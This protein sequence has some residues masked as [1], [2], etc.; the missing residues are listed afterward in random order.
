MVNKQIFQL[1]IALCFLIP[2]CGDGGQPGNTYSVQGRYVGNYSNGQEVIVLNQDNTFTQT[3]SRNGVTQ[4]SLDGTWE[5][6]NE[7]IVF[8][9]FIVVDSS[10]PKQYGHV[11]GSLHKKGEV[12]SFNPDTDYFIRKSP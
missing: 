7:S 9:P 2:S 4:H 1:M 6:R 8:S 11:E 12:I 3:F 10:P 5:L